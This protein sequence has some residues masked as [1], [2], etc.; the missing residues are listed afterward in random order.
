MVGRKTKKNDEVNNNNT[1]KVA[2]VPKKRG[3]KSKKELALL[4]KQQEEL[5]NTSKKENAV[6]SASASTSTS[7]STSATKSNT[8]TK[9]NGKVPK[10]RGRKPKG[11]KIIQPLSE[12][13]T[14]NIEPIENIILHLKCST[15]D[16]ELDNIFLSELIYNPNVESVKAYDETNSGFSQ[17]YYDIEVNDANL[18]SI[19][20]N[21]QFES[22]IND[23]I[24]DH[25]HEHDKKTVTEDECCQN[26]KSISMK[27]IWGK[28]KELQYNLHT[29][30]V[31]DN[32]SDCFWCTCSFDNPSIHIPKHKIKDSYEVYGC[33]CTPECATA[34]LF[35]E[36]IDSSTKWE[37]YSLLNSVYSSIYNYEN[38]IKPAPSPHYLLDKY[39]GNLSINEYRKLLKSNNILLVVDKPLTRVL[40][41]VFEENNEYP[42]SNKS[43][44]KKSKY[45][46]SRNKPPINKLESNEKT[47]L[48]TPN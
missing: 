11:G 46:L 43:N 1:N 29:N 27:S 47:W 3:R 42:L 15:K 44:S 26:D 21:Q 7:T 48:F 8:K 10:K 28:L 36:R 24:H 22:K 2:K 20:C 40:P 25:V 14:V 12:N 38:N 23:Q 39:Y 5:A 17:Q 41:E 37:R 30:N 34:Y 9:T 33:F 32:N 45:K 4:K 35:S 31:S 13:T 18:N 19:V 16:I 6:L